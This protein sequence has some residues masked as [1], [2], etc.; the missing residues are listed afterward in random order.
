MLVQKDG[1][2]RHV[3]QMTDRHYIPPWL[4]PGDRIALVSSARKFSKAELESTLAK[5]NEWDF[6]LVHSEGLFEEKNQFAG[7]DEHRAAEFEKA[8]LDD[9]IQAVMCAKGGYGTI[10]M[11]QYLDMNKLLKKPKWLVGYSDATV[12]HFAF[13]QAGIASLHATMPV[14]FQSNTARSIDLIPTCLKGEFRG[15]AEEVEVGRPG[16]CEGIMIGGSL[17][18][19]YGLLSQ[20]HLIDWSKHVLFIED[21]D[22]HL[23]HIDRM[24]MALRQAGVLQKVQG[25]VI[26]SMIDMRDNTREFGFKTDNPFGLDISQIMHHA[27]RDTTCPWGMQFPSGHDAENLP[28]YL[29]MKAQCDYEGNTLSISYSF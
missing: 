29:G 9:S 28:L 11:M 22:E 19:L 27:M 6:E 15:Y 3:A 25:L 5:T 23:Y 16:R 4:K 26:G 8:F 7:S 18:I 14:S 2:D 10:R 13:Q 24:M 21:L 1:K 17:S 12:L 20:Q